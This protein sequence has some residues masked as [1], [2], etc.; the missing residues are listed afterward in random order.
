LPA[1]GNDKEELASAEEDD[2][3]TGV[4]SAIAVVSCSATLSC[5]PSCRRYFVLLSNAQDWDFF[6]FEG[7]VFFTA[8]PLEDLVDTLGFSKEDAANALD[9]RVLRKTLFSSFE[10]AFSALWAS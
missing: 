1:G 2:C 4:C 8:E 3:E 10:A 5:T 7:V 9:E 6:F